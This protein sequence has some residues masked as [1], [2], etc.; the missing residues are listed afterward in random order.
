MLEENLRGTHLQPFVKFDV[1]FL[2]CQEGTSIHVVKM[3]ELPPKEEAKASDGYQES[4]LK[5]SVNYVVSLSQASCTVAE[6]TETSFV[7]TI[8]IL[9][10]FFELLGPMKASPRK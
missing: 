7:L 5:Q 6:V 1:T 8:S 4:Y 3:D 9:Q 10:N 2:Q